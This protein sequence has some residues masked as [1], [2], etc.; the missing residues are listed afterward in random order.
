VTHR[1]HLLVHAAGSVVHPSVTDPVHLNL[2]LGASELA[3]RGAARASGAC[4]IHTVVHSIYMYCQRQSSGSIKELLD[5]Q[6]PFPLAFGKRWGVF[7]LHAMVAPSVI[8]D[9]AT[10]ACN[11]PPGTYSALLCFA[12]VR[13]WRAW[14]GCADALS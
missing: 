10:A 9:G 4:R 1:R 11:E 6:G 7:P 13:R 5:I 12:C 3:F 2:E 14:G 8:S